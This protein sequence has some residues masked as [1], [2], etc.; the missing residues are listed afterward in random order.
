MFWCIT[1]IGILEDTEIFYFDRYL[2]DI[3]KKL[4]QKSEII[5][6]RNP[7]SKVIIVA[8]ECSYKS[9]MAPLSE[10]I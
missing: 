4:E 3:L 9:Y 1:E 7:L 8:I 10:I 6:P 2:A 5:P